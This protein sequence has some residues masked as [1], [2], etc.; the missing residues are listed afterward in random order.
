MEAVQQGL[1]QVVQA[2]NSFG[3]SASYFLTY[4]L[5][6]LGFNS[7]HL[8]PSNWDEMTA[9]KTVFIKFQAPW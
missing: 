2:L 3:N 7:E 9:G 5:A 6:L 8:T 1:R 4:V